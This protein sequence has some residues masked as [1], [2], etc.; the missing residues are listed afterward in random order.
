V[1]KNIQIDIVYESDSYSRTMELFPLP[2]HYKEEETKIQRWMMNESTLKDVPKAITSKEVEH[3]IEY[4]K[5]YG[6]ALFVELYSGER[7]G[8]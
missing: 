4:E 6:I 1:N 5:G 3:L 2:I 7:I 8:K